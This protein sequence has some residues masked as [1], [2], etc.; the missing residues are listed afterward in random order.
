M[1]YFHSAKNNIP[2]SLIVLH[3]GPGMDHQYLVKGLAFIKK[4]RQLIFYDQIGCGENST[5]SEVSLDD[6]IQQLQEQ[7]KRVNGEYGLIAHSW[8]AILVYELVK[9]GLHKNLKEVIFIN[10]TPLTRQ[11][12]NQAFESFFK[13][14]DPNVISKI[15]A[16][17]DPLEQ[18][19]AALPFYLADPE[20]ASKIYI[21]NYNPDVGSRRLMK[22]LENYDYRDVIQKLPFRTIWITGEK[23][24]FVQFTPHQSVRKFIIE[25]AGHYVFYEKPEEFEKI[26]LDFFKGIF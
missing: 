8:G 1:G 15:L 10:P 24:L 5:D 4:D 22:D 25:N 3:G 21:Q 17:A 20:N 12:W 18:V 26:M 11:E 16:I 19:R 2:I 14:I 7:I 13:K 9:R 6:C 23:D